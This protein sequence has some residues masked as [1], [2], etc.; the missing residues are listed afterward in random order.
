MYLEDVPWFVL[1]SA[2]PDLV[3]PLLSLGSRVLLEAS[4]AEPVRS[5]FAGV[6]VLG[7]A[8]S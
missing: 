6:V 5:E 7:G 4:F 8:H 3:L 2:I 1:E